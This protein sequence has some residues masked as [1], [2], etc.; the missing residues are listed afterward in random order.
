[1]VNVSIARRYARAL[2]EVA[3]ENNALDQSLSVLEA[4]TSLLDQNA[5][6][7]DLAVNPA[8]NRTQK[9][10]ITEKVLGAVGA[11]DTGLMNFFRL[12]V[13]RNRLGS[14]P[15]ITRI[16][17]DLADTRAG[18]VRGVVTSAKPLAADSLKKLEESLERITQRDV[19]LQ[20]QVDPALLGG[21]SAQV[22]SVV[23]DGS[24]RTQIQTLRQSLKAAR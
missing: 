3:A 6:L 12:L 11:K 16:F 22:G 20:T 17:R 19:V 7:K 9:W 5:E 18:R 13:D 8:Y 23:Y 24:L 1:M 10:A 2:L 21:V 15:D 4:F 14:L